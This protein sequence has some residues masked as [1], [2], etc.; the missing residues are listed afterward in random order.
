MAKIAPGLVEGEV[1]DVLE[2]GVDWRLRD[3]RPSGCE[4]FWMIGSACWRCL[5][6]AGKNRDPNEGDQVMQSYV[7]LAGNY[8]SKAT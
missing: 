8:P 3:G 7:E 6:I 2:K 4:G 1:F 5:G